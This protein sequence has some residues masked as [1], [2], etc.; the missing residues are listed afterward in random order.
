MAE[1][2]CP[3]V[4]PVNK[5]EVNLDYEKK[6]RLVEEEAQSLYLFCMKKGFTEEE[7]STCV[8]KLRGPEKPKLRKIANDSTTSCLRLSLV[9]A[10]VTALWMT[11]TGYNMLAVHAK[12][13]SIK[14]ILPYWDWATLYQEECLINNPWL[15]AENTTIDAEFCQYCT[16]MVKYG[17]NKVDR[18]NNTKGAEIM[19]HYIQNS[20]PVVVTD[21]TKDWGSKKRIAMDVIANLYQTDKFLST[22]MGSCNYSTNVGFNETFYDFITAYVDGKLPKLWHANW[23]NCENKAGKI[24]RQFYTRPYFIP[25]MAQAGTENSVIASFGQHPEEYFSVPINTQS[26][27]HWITVV[28]GSLKFLLTPNEGCMDLFKCKILE[29]M[30]YPGETVFFTEGDWDHSYTPT[31]DKLTLAISSSVVWDEI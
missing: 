7:I 2:F 20:Q 26:S 25:D 8:S 4:K 16:N 6:L 24:F 22:V 1:E 3:K 31:D 17:N 12:L 29:V 18:L 27:G 13:F 28:T 15:P 5:N 9:L 21:T 11:P 14:V 19:K 30:L 10:L 23:Q